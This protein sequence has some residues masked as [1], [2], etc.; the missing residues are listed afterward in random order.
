MAARRVGVFK[1][2]RNGCT[3][4]LHGTFMDTVWSALLQFGTDDSA[5]H[6]VISTKYRFVLV[7]QHNDG[8]DVNRRPAPSLFSREPKKAPHCV[9]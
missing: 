3:R 8:H 4:F 7:V 5:V 9:H 2:S 6:C 1:R